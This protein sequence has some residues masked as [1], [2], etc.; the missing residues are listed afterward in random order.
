MIDILSYDKNFRNENFELVESLRLKNF[1]KENNSL[2]TFRG[3]VVILD[4]DKAISIKQIELV[5]K[6]MKKSS[7]TQVVFKAHI[8]N[9]E[10]LSKKYKSINFQK[11]DIEKLI[12]T[13]SHFFCSNNTTLSIELISSGCNTSIMDSGTNLDMDPSKIYGLETIKIKSEDDLLIFINSNQNNQSK[14]LFELN[15]DFP[16][17][18]KLLIS[19]NN[20]LILN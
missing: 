9:Y 13:N 3:L 4:Y 17:W 18:K 15:N 16:L 12:N 6:F 7:I 10:Y 19:L 11:D 5:L 8:N 20:E 14:N 2:N 1:K